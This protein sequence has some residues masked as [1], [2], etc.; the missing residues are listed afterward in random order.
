LNAIP[1]HWFCLVF[2]LLN[3]LLV[4][5]LMWR[6]FNSPWAA[7]IAAVFFVGGRHKISRGMAKA[8]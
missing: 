5:A 4:F 3:T 1:Y 7:W 8:R 6:L 2:H